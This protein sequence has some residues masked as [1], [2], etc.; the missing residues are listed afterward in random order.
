MVDRLLST[1]NRHISI[2]SSFVGSN[3]EAKT[4]IT[5]PC[6]GLVSDKIG[7]ELKRNGFHVAFK[8][9][10]ILNRLFIWSKDKIDIWDKSGVYKL[11]CGYCSA[12]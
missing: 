6:L 5:I 2:N 7:R 8:T 11:E 1:I 10:P 12:C 3:C 4:W 9:K